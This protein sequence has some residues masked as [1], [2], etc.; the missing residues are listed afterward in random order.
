M[1]AVVAVEGAVPVA[2]LV[3]PPALGDVVVDQVAL[4]V[5]V[6]RLLV[7][8]IEGEGII[9]FRRS[10]SDVIGAFVSFSEE[11]SYSREKRRNYLKHLAIF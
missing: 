3:G 5:R 7:L 2:L 10:R 8:W 1:V 4:R 9:P 11:N 6:V